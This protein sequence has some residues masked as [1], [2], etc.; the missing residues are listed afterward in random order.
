MPR[1]VGTVYTLVCLGSEGTGQWDKSADK[2]DVASCN[3]RACQKTQAELPAL[4]LT[5]G[6]QVLERGRGGYS[7]PTI[8]SGERE[9]RWSPFQLASPDQ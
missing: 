3:Y 8:G 4:R 6:C 5:P 7:A 9:H 1:P 2:I